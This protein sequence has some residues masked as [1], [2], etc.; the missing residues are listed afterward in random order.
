MAFFAVVFVVGKDYWPTL[1]TP[2]IAV[3]KI[4]ATLLIIAAFFQIFDGAQA[5][6]IGVTRGV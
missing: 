5:V 6:G 2:D 1:Y 4:A 3:Q